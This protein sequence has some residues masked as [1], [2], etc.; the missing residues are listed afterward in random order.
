MARVGPGLRPGRA[1]RSSAAFCAVGTDLSKP[2]HHP[3]HS[4]LLRPAP[5]PSASRCTDK[6]FATRA[7][8]SKPPNKTRAVHSACKDQRAPGN[9]VLRSI[10]CQASANLPSWLRRTLAGSAA[11]PSLRC[12]RSIVRLA[13]PRAAPLS[14]TCVH[15]RDAAVRSAKAQAARDRVWRSHWRKGS[16]R[17]SRQSPTAAASQWSPTQRTRREG[18]FS[19]FPRA[20]SRMH[21]SAKASWQRHRP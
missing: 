19:T 13:P 5:H 14:K 10:E 18:L 2:A 21:E 9:P 15:A 3:N 16:S 12:G 4:E 7:V 1:E 17:C 8:F 6:S 11:G 20:T